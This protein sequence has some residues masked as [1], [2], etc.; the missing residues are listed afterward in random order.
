MSEETTIL[1][2]ANT[3]GFSHSG[4][5]RHGHELGEL[6]LSGRISDEGRSNLRAIS[7]SAAFTNASQ[8]RFGIAIRSDLQRVAEEFSHVRKDISEVRDLIRETETARLREHLMEARTKIIAL[9][10]SVA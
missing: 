3:P 4:G 9:E 1:P 8:E 10:A 7:E 2:G 6:V 5:S